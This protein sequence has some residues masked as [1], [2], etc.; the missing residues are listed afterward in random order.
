LDAALHV[1]A[2]FLFGFT[3]GTSMR[4]LLLVIAAVLLAVVAT[5][6]LLVPFRVGALLCPTI[7]LSA[8]LLLFTVLRV[9]H[10]TSPLA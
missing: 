9:S 5:A 10:E 2:L 1:F 3:L 6:L 7:R 4:A 8:L